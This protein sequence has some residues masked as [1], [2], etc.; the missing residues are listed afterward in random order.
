MIISKIIRENKNM[1]KFGIDNITE[2]EL[3]FEYDKYYRDLCLELKNT[4]SED[5]RNSIRINQKSN[6][7]LLNNVVINLDKLKKNFIQLLQDEN[8]AK[9]L[10]TFYSK[11]D[12]NEN[13]IDKLSNTLKEENKI[14]RGGTNTYK[15][16][17]WMTHTLYVYQIVN[18]NI[19]NNIKISNLPDN[20]NTKKELEELHKKY[21]S[22]NDKSKFILKV[23]TLIHDIGV[24]E[25]VQYHDKFGANY[26]EKVLKELNI[27]K[28]SLD[29]N[30]ICINIE[31]L[32]KIL[33]TIIIHHTLITALSAEAND[34][35]ME[36]TY[37]DLINNIPNISE[38]KSQIPEILFIMAYADIIAVD[39]S[40]MDIEKYQRTKE[41]Y[42]FFCEVSEGKEHNRNKQK[43]AIERI[44]DTVGKISFNDLK[45]RLDT[46]LDKNK[47]DKNN[48]IDNMYDIKLFRYTGPLMKTVND[49]ELSIRIYN[50]LFNLIIYFDGKEALKEYRI[51][52]VPSKREEQI[53]EQFKN[54]NF[55]ECVDIMKGQKKRINTYKNISIEMI[56]IDNEKNILVKVI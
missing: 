48:F 27:T 15:L 29:E 13:Y 55:F 39:E 37:K 50:E 17:G 26:V 33:K 19:C 20:E 22:L 7:K 35:F 2:K 21:I 23:F 24:I 28:E 40:L 1:C 49:I 43:V 10:W 36:D 8:S 3:N 42:N 6:F 45:N 52:F 54:G 51:T 38:I 12:A 4:V 34:I 25:N 53:A 9:Y 46:I 47:I 11:Y 31:D 5:E 14:I 56:E 18:Y 32:I 44:C 41:G 30:N 16:N